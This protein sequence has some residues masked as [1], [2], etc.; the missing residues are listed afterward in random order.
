VRVPVCVF[1]FLVILLSLRTAEAAL[2][3]RSDDPASDYTVITLSGEIT[4]EDVPEFRRAV[5]EVDKGLVVLAS[6][7]GRLRAS[8]EIG[9]SVRMRQ[10]ATLVPKGARCTSGCALIWLSGAAR[11]LHERA[12][13]GFHAAYVEEGGQVRET[14]VGNAMVGVFLNE[15][16]YPLD[17]VFE[18]TRAAPD[19]MNILTPWMAQR[20]GLEVKWLFDDDENPAFPPAEAPAAPSVAELERE[21]GTF[22]RRF[23]QHHETDEPFPPLLV[24]RHYARHVEHFGELINRDEL[25]RRQR[26][27]AERWPVHSM[28]LDG[29]PEARCTS[30]ARCTVTGLATFRARSEARNRRSEGRLRYVFRLEQRVD[31]FVIVAEASDVLERDTRPIRAGEARLVRRIQGELIRVGCNPGPLDGVWGPQT[32]A[33]LGRF[34]RAYNVLAPVASPTR[35]ALGRLKSVRGIICSD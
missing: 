33:A 6:P 13:L 28:S 26:R 27:Y 4:P 7:G 3:E 8:L 25:K 2:I 23:M 17:L 21:A 20:I 14:G 35:Q 9:R 29:E 18:A 34:N 1:A 11:A 32:A 30:D 19:D 12:V 10:L 31:T 15:L 24:G 16:G 5:A 22:V